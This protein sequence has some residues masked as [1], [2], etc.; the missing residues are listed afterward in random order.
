MIETTSRVAKTGD[1]FGRYT[2]LGIY[3]DPKI[4]KQRYARVQC[5]CGSPPRYSRV[6]GL[7]SGKAQSCGCLHKE[8]VTTHGAWGTPL[9]KIWSAMIRRCTKPQDKKYHRYGGR[10]IKVCERWLNVNNFIDDMTEGY[11]AGLQIDRIDNDGNYEPSN[12]QWSTR[13]QQSRNYSRNVILEH[14]GKRMC[15]VDWSLVVGIP[16]KSIYQRISD[17]WSAKDTLTKPINPRIKRQRQ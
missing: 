7:T 1:R 14:D 10:G 12:C 3:F 17:G 6:D 9:F 5:D 8:V 11:L 4:S 16:A 2:I 13:K 15:V